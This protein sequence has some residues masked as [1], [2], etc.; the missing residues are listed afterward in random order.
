MK[1]QSVALM[2]LCIS[3][4]FLPLITNAANKPQSSAVDYTDSTTVSVLMNRIDEIRSMDKSTLSQSEKKNL[5]KEARSIKKDLK[6]I[7]NGGI[8]LSVG[9]I[10]IIILLLILI[11]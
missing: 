11:L 8:Y 7:E 4:S 2:I 6:R 1:K 3:L 10:I 9:A 5:N